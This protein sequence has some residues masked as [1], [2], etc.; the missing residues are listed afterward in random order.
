[1]ATGPLISQN[2][3]FVWRGP[4]HAP[5]AERILTKID[6]PMLDHHRNILCSSHPLAIARVTI[7]I[8]RFRRVY[9][10]DYFLF[11]ALA[12][13]ISSNALLF[14][15]VPELYLFASASTGQILPHKNFF[16]TVTDTA[17]FTTTAGIPSC[18]TIFAV[19]FS[20][21]FYFRLLVERL[22]RL[23]VG[24]GSFLLF[25][26]PSP[27][28]RCA[29]TSSFAPMWD[30]EYYVSL[31]TCQNFLHHLVYRELTGFAAHCFTD[32]GFQR[33]ARI[34]VYYSAISDIVTDAL[35]KHF[36]P[37]LLHLPNPSP[38]YRP[39]AWHLCP[40]LRNPRADLGILLDPARDL[41]QRH[42]GQH[43]DLQD[44]VRRQQELDPGQQELA[45]Q[46]S[47]R[48]SVEEEA[49]VATAGGS[50]DRRDDDGDEEYD[51]V[52]EG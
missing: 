48:A 4:L 36:L 49:D 37:T 20:F 31:V 8:Y 11:L 7:R 16:Q 25:A 2:A 3:Y 5:L 28:H 38:I 23:T 32:A 33:R 22:P 13:L 30:P 50:G 15:S 39:G 44:P 21:L 27:S 1:M 42:H 51:I 26:F 35:S 18:I 19:K 52:W 9:A 14:A 43:H 29:V 41:R 40:R 46:L 6:I 24:G 17:V 34:V 12:A 45:P 47:L 10:D